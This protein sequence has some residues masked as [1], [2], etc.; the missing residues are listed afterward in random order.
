M[1]LK[2]VL[3][4]LEVNWSKLIRSRCSNASYDEVNWYSL[5]WV[6]LKNLEG[7]LLTHRNKLSFI[8][9]SLC[10]N[11][12]LH[13]QND[14]GISRMKFGC[15]CCCLP[16]LLLFANAWATVWFMFDFRLCICLQVTLINIPSIFTRFATS[17][18]SVDQILTDLLLLI[19]MAYLH[20]TDIDVLALLL[21][22]M[23]IVTNICLL[24]TWMY[25]LLVPSFIKWN[26]SIAPI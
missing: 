5:G 25:C 18:C 20:N 19:D 10:S 2:V 26:C 1:S 17:T 9:K 6:V 7:Y 21:V 11:L 14:F 23:I 8:L 3:K 24:Y 4:N 12:R 16:S 22:L 15:A 13:I